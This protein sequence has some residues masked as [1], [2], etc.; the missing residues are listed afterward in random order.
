MYM[1]IHRFIGDFNIREEHFRITEGDLVNQIKNVLK[2]TKG[3]ELILYTGSLEEARC[4]IEEYGKNFVEVHVVER[5]MNANEPKRKVTLYL[6]T[7]KRENFEL[8]AQKATEAGVRNIVPI[9]S[10]RTVK[11][12][13]ST[14]RVEKIVKEAAE[15][16]GRGMVPRIADVVLFEKIFPDA[17]K[18][19]INIFFDGAGKQFSGAMLE[20]KENIGIFIGPEGGWGNKELVEAKENGFLIAGLGALTLRAETAATIAS[21][22]ACNS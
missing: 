21:Y 17:A 16:S 22:L 8:A 9:I 13:I 1:K 20:G 3:E 5:M 19:D 2:L 12:N 11:L 14:E 4:R 15:Q 18:N 6:S 10:S 7:L